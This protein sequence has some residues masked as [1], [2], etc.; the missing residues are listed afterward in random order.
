MKPNVL[1]LRAAGTNCDAETAH[2]FAIAGAEPTVVHVNRLR[3]RPALLAEYRILAI[4]GGFSYGDDVAS[5]RVFA[6]ELMSA[7][8]D[9][10]L[11]FVDRGGFAI[12]ICNGFQVLVKAGLLP[13]IDGKAE[14]QAT[15]TDNLSGIY[16]DRWV[17][18]VGNPKLCQWIPDDQEIEL[19]V[20]HAEG[21]FVAP[22]AVLDRLEAAGQIALRYSSGTNH[23]GSARDIAGICDPTGRIFGLMPH[24]ERFLR[25]EN[26]PRWTREPR[27]EEGDGARYFRQAVRRASE[28]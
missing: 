12:G 20:A 7:L 18:T 8:R 5:G 3:E 28:G 19:P 10:L 23:N 6:N 14:Q 9:E 15:L 25:W 26:H 17:R 16:C 21:R 27:R 1:V 4:P 22:D 2:A 13:R 24:P 11:R